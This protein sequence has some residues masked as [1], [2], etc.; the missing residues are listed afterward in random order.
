MNKKLKTVL[1]ILLVIVL[2]AMIPISVLVI[3]P[4]YA[5][6]HNRANLEIKTAAERSVGS[7]AI[8]FLNTGSSDAILIESCGKFALIDA[9][10]DNDNPRHFEG[11]ELKGYED[12]VVA[13]IKKN[14]AGEDGRVMLDFVLGTHSHSDH[15]GGFDTVIADDSID[16]GRAYLKEYDSNKVL[17]YEVEQWDNQ[18]VYDQMVKALN[19]KNVPIISQP[20]SEPFS[21]GNFTVTIFNTTDEDNEKVGENDHSFGVLLEKNGTKIFLSGDIDNLSGD[22]D[23]LAPEIGDIDLLKIGHHS[24]YGST[25]SN[26]VQTLSPEYC[27]V[28]NNKSSADPRIIWR[29]ERK[30]NSAI[31]FTG[32]ENGVIAEI[33]DNGSIQFY[34]S[35]Y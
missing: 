20:D 13:Y 3:K 31:L 28:T 17:D 33:G 8:H 30:A 11:L 5:L 24:Y 21:L 23:R 10:E 34:N 6:N 26:W 27:V 4:A 29:I 2:A 25:T 19:A 16:I 14:A 7:D 35:I 32:E 12:E 9:G 15:I 1:I 18:E 22:E